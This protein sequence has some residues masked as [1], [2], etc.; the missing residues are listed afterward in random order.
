MTSHSES[1][2]A[3]TALNA[4]SPI[5]PSRPASTLRW[6]LANLEEL[7]TAILLGVM[8]G[9]VG[10]SVF[11]RYILQ[12]PPSWTEEV[13]LL[14]MVWTC[15]LG[16]RIVT[17]PKEHQQALV[18]SAQTAFRKAMKPLYET[19]DS[20]WTKELRERIQAVQ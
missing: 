4:S 10:L 19:Y 2:P 6:I 11:C 14:C 20:V 16:A 5:L 9:S 17:K 13:V 3:G 15:F 1:A 7:I 12:M 18:E 8:I